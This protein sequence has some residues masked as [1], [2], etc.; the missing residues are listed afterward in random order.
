MELVG[1]VCDG[2][3]DLQAE[4]ALG[5]HT[6]WPSGDRAVGGAGVCLEEALSLRGPWA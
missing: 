3:D 6:A 1:L 5:V 2:E 4:G